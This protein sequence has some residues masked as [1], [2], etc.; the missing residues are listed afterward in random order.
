MSEPF[1][2]EIA[3]QVPAL[4]LFVYAVTVFL[5]HLSEE[6]KEI[7]TVVAGVKEFQRDLTKE[8]LQALER[9]SRVVEQNTAQLALSRDAFRSERKKNRLV[10]NRESKA[11]LL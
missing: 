3:K 8:N 5:K 7:H 4:L 11:Q 1:W 10:R 9:L 6:R 2:I